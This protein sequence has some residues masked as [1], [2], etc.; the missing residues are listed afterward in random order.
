[1]LC[2]SPFVFDGLPVGCGRC[3]MCKVNHRRMW[4]GR[5]L[6]ESLNHEIA[7]FVTLTYDDDNV[8]F[9][10]VP[11]ESGEFL[12]T[13]CKY[14]IVDFFKRLRYYMSVYDA[15]DGVLLRYFYCGEYGDLRGRPHYHIALFSLDERDREILEKSWTFGHV[16]FDELNETTMHYICGYVMKKMTKSDDLRLQGREPEFVG[17]SRRPALGSV[18]VDKLILN[19]PHWL[20]DKYGDVVNEFKVG[21]NNRYVLGR[22]LR[23]KLRK[24][25]GVSDDGNAPKGKKEILQA[26]MLYVSRGAKLSSFEKRQLLMSKDIHEHRRLLDYYKI[27]AHSR[28]KAS[29]AEA[30]YKLR[31]QRNRPVERDLLDEKTKI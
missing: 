13:L 2:K 7:S 11:S 16:R 1:M 17:G 14:H 19:P 12:Q 24:A 8:P 10:D 18:I 23:S 31:Q 22:T 20:F 30:R 9:M 27:R 6:L 5:L 3:E 25:L 29:S 4:T 15:Y 28:Q 21:K 26:E